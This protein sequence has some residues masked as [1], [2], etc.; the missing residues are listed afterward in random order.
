MFWLKIQVLWDLM[1]FLSS[2]S[3]D[4]S[5]DRTADVFGFALKMEALPNF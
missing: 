3:P 5:T 1:L 4:V 2:I